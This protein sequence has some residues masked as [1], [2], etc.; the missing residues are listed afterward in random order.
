MNPVTVGFAKCISHR[1]FIVRSWVQSV[2]CRRW[3]GDGASLAELNILPVSNIRST[4][5]RCM[6]Q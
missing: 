1:R 5:P 6:L 2:A 4:A 3:V